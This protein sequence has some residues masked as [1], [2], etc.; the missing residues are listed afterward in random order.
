MKKSLLLIVLSLTI[1]I[2][3]MSQTFIT[4]YK[5]TGSK[6]W[7]Y[8]DQNG[9]TI[10]EPEFKKCFMFSESGIAPIYRSKNY[11]FIN[12]KGEIIKTEITG[13]RLIKGFAGIGGLQGYSDGLIAI[14]KDDKWGFLNTDGNIA[15]ELKYDKVSSFNKGVATAQLGDDFFVLNKNGNE[16][17]IEGDNVA[18]VKHFVNNF[19][20]FTSTAKQSGFIGTD[21]KIAIPA[22][23]TSVGY[24]VADLAWAKT[25]DKKIGYINTKGEWV[26]EPQFLAAKNFDPVSG[27]AR[28]KTANGWAYVNKSG[29]MLF[30]KDTQ[31]WGDFYD[32]L[33]KGKKEGKTGYYNNKGEWV[34]AA[35]YEGGRNFKNG[36]AAVKKNDKWGFINTK[37]EWVIDAQF[38]G[39][40]DLEKVK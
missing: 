38:A 22:E 30:V 35:E 18:S 23:F 17:L 14:T 26:I 15:I 32:G 20:A 25:A 27:L 5:P 2:A 39:V 36:F 16:T 11:I 28:V 24:F 19:A 6:L 37:G 10:I 33:A 3:A 34:V 13:F 1:T 9:K 40:K 21:G 12:T 29:E 8:M 4:Q 31:T 7:G